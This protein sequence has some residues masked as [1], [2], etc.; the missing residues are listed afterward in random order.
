MT[1]KNITVCGLFEGIGGFPFAAS[2][3]N[4]QALRQ[5][6]ELPLF[7]WLISTDND[8]D[9]IEVLRRNFN[10]KIIDSCIRD[11][12]VS[13]GINLILGGFPCK[14]TTDG[15][16]KTGLNHPESS[17]YKEFIR[18]V[19]EA[20]P[21]IVL[22]EQPSGFIYRGYDTWTYEISELGYNNLD[23]IIIACCQIGSEANRNRGIYRRVRLFSLSYYADR[24]CSIRASEWYDCI[25]DVVEET[26]N[27]PN[28]LTVEYTGDAVIAWVPSGLAATSLDEFSLDMRRQKGRIRSR[29]LIG[30]TVTVPQA[31]IALLSAR[32]LWQ[33]KNC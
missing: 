17:L 7:D 10:H 12:H 33:R 3:I 8:P 18:C 23:P 21:D 32:W 25:R 13:P 2:Q 24:F 30:R 6:N 1:G 28:W 31:R 15:G 26:A 19:K 4:Q 20:Q 27:Y 11:F 16:T 14:G 9:S 5:T 22:L 29:K